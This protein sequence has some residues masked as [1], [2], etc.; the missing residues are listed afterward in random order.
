M[1]SDT[2]IG[3]TNGNNIGTYNGYTFD[4]TYGTTNGYNFANDTLYS[5]SISY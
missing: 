3:K 4:T 2:Y 5:Y 1:T